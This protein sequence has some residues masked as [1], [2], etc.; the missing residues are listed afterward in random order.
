MFKRKTGIIVDPE[1]NQDHNIELLNSYDNNQEPATDEPVEQ[2]KVIE[3]K[4]ENKSVLP[5]LKSFGSKSK[6]V[7]SKKSLINHS[8][9][10]ISTNR[11]GVDL[12]LACRCLPR[13]D[14][15][16]DTDP[17]IVLFSKSSKDDKPE[18]IGFT[19]L[20]LNNCNPIWKKPIRVPIDTRGIL[21]KVFDADEY[22]LDDETYQTRM[23]TSRLCGEATFTMEDIML[24]HDNQCSKKFSG[25]INLTFKKPSIIV[26][27]HK[28]IQLENQLPSSVDSSNIV[29]KA[30]DDLAHTRWFTVLTVLATLLAVVEPLLISW[31]PP[32]NYFD[33]QV[34][35]MLASTG[36]CLI[37]AVTLFS[38]LPKYIVDRNDLSGQSMVN[39]TL[40]RAVLVVIRDTQTLFE[41]FFLG[42]GWVCWY[43]YP[44]LAALRCLRVFRFFWTFELVDVDAGD[45]LYPIVSQGRICLQFMRAIGYEFGSGSRSRGAVLLI[46]AFFFLNYLVSVVL[47][48]AVS[49]VTTDLYGG[50]TEV[51]LCSDIKHCMLTLFRLS[52]YESIG[53]DFLETVL[54]DSRRW[55]LSAVLVLYLIA[56]SII[57]LN[58]LIGIFGSLFANHS[59][60]GGVKLE[61]VTDTTKE[62]DH[63]RRHTEGMIKSLQEHSDKTNK[64]VVDMLLKIGNALDEGASASKMSA[65]HYRHQYNNNMD[66]DSV[67]TRGEK[68]GQRGDGGGGGGGG[69]KKRKGRG[70][71]DGGDNRPAAVSKSTVFIDSKY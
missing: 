32:G 53:F 39:L 13:M 21:V 33:Y 68:P 66:D 28:P 54:A 31:E 9:D 30:R 59:E 20:I 27:A 38:Y 12:Y 41:L 65:M 44:S 56:T 67:D 37:G 42:L 14:V 58:G 24:G 7:L 52:F 60:F 49:D 4:R 61:V 29:K 23:Q 26:R 36:L 62:E 8:V 70:N 46:L 35:V 22:V 71:K 50:V 2:N 64:Q 18:Y 63:A 43:S 17:F 15:Y 34:Y 45:L 57:I 48:N 16:S 10:H 3:I 25:G 1:P 11:D 19:K 40:G 5:N 69:R 55:P 51:Y 47:S 6:Q